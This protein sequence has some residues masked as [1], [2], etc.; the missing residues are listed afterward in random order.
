MEESLR[1]EI[2]SGAKKEDGKENPG[3][4]NWMAKVVAQAGVLGPQ[5]RRQDPRSAVAAA[6]PVAA[7]F[8]FGGGCVAAS[9]EERVGTPHHLSTE[10]ATRHL[11]RRSLRVGLDEVPLKRDGI[12]DEFSPSSLHFTVR[13]PMDDITLTHRAEKEREKVDLKLSLNCNTWAA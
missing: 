1:E 12:L 9:G 10:K 13:S 4:W 2:E 11:H 6:A 8:G 7:E 3:C 5:L